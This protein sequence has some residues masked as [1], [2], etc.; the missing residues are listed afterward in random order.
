MRFSRVTCA[1]ASVLLVASITFF[2][3]SPNASASTPP[4]TDYRPMASGLSVPMTDS[5]SPDCVL[6]LGAHNS[7]VGGL[8]WVIAG[9]Y[10]NE[11]TVNVWHTDGI[12]G[13]AT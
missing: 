11:I 9:C 5:G 2:G 13:P 7:A 12:F 1:A 4:C 3:F 8:Q 10:P 6:R